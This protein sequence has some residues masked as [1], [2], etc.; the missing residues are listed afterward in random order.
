MQVD[1]KAEAL[2][3]ETPFSAMGNNP[4]FKADPLGDIWHIVAGAGFGGAFNVYQQWG[5]IGN[6]QDGLV[7]FGIGAAAGAVGAATGG[8]IGG[9][10]GSGLTSLSAV[11]VNGAIV[12]AGS[13][14]SE[15]FLRGTANAF[16]FNDAS[17]MEALD[18]G[19]GAG[20]LGFVNG[21]SAGGTMAVASA[22][23]IGKI[24][25]ILTTIQTGDGKKFYPFFGDT[26]TN[27]KSYE[28]THTST[29]YSDLSSTQSVVANSGTKSVNPY[30]PRN[31]GALG[32]WS[33]EILYPGTRID[34]FG[35]DFGK[36]LSP[37]GT[38]LD[39]RAL[40]PG[41][42]GTYNAYKVLKPFE[43][44][45]S[46][47]AP[48]FGKLGLGKQYLSPVSVKTLLKRGIITTIK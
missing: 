26:G 4:I 12:G 8:A 9:V 39:M 18:S 31:D 46:T 48:A 11:A 17:V 41:N 25:S 40:P 2:Y 23:V 29:G 22:L 43:V 27:V 36:Y 24:T 6:F 16:Y 44:Q 37:H 21:F 35:E 19:A 30:Y 47:I 20:T 10:L 33:N 1:P 7:A 45:S 42:T 32:K 5:N 3:S 14:A 15:E 34:R 28:V 38:P 13:L